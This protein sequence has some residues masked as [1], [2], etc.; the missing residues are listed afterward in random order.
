MRK[1]LRAG[2][3]HLEWLTSQVHEVEYGPLRLVLRRS[4]A[5]RRKEQRRRHD[6]LAT[7]HELITTRNAFVRT[8]KRARPEAGWRS[9]SAWVKRHKLSGCVQVA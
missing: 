4:E 8:S 7:L 6:K 1:L 3:V 5:V 9:L 2:V